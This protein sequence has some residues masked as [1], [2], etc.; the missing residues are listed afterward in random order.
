M[1]SAAILMSIGA[2]FN[3]LTTALP[4]FIHR[5][6]VFYP[7]PPP[8]DASLAARVGSVIMGIGYMNGESFP[9]HPQG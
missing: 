8:E 5:H 9:K 3:S 1:F 4:H 7:T 2:N 6:A